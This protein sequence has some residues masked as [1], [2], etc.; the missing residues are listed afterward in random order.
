MARYLIYSVMVRGISKFEPFTLYKDSMFAL[1]ILSNL[2]NG[3]EI[4]SIVEEHS[5]LVLTTSFL[6]LLFVV[7]WF[8]CSTILLW[9]A[10]L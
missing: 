10:F 3:L 2:T 1:G 8:S 5:I 9:M 4:L 6:K 7:S